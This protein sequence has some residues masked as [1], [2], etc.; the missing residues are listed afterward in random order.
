[1]TKI[2]ITQFDYDRLKGL[3]AKKIPHDDFDKALLY[4]LERA[5]IV[6]PKDIPPDVITRSKPMATTRKVA[7]GCTSL[8]HPAS[9]SSGPISDYGRIMVCH[10]VHWTVSERAFQLR[11][12]RKQME[13]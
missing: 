9:L 7:A 12:W 4:E 8:C 3:L 10:I 5:E 1:M 6:E 13:P 11:S 2:Y